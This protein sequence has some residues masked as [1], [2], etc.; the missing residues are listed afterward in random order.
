MYCVLVFLFLFSKRLKALTVGGKK[1]KSKLFM[2]LRSL[3]IPQEVGESTRYNQILW[4]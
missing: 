1:K 3:D 4:D 2:L